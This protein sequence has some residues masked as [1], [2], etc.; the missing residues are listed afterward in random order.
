MLENQLAETLSLDGVWEIEIAGLSGE[1]VVPGVWERQGYPADVERAVYRRSVD[2]PARWA[3][4]RLFLRFGAVSYDVEVLVN[5]V[6][7]GRHEGM[8]T[9]F[10]LDVTEVV[11]PG[12]ANTVE[13]RIVKPLGEGDSYPYREVLVGFIPYIAITFGGPWQPVELVAYRSAAL[14]VEQ[15]SA[16]W[17]T[18]VVSLK[19]GVE[20]LGAAPEVDTRL[21]AEVLDDKGLVVASAQM[22]S[23][24]AVAFSLAVPDARLWSPAAPMCY[25]L[26]LWLLA[27]EVVLAETTRAFGF[28]ALQAD[29]DRLLLNGEVVSLR[30]VLSWGWKPSTL[31]PMPTDDE[32]RD[33]FR[34]VRELGFNLIKLCLFVPPPRL[35][36]IADEEGM[37]LW[38]ELPM[39]WQRV[40]P[41]LR[42][43]AAIEYRDIMWAV[44]HHPSVVIY[45]L[46]CE[47]GADMA[48]AEMLSN[49]NALVRGAA[50]N[51][52]VCDNSGSGEAYA[53]LSFDYADFLDYHFYSDLHY[54]VPLLDHFRRD[55]RK[56]RPWIFGEYCD[57]DSYRD[58]AELAENGARPWWRDV[59]GVE[60]N[61]SRWAFNQQERRVAAHALP[62]DDQTIKRASERQSFVVRKYVL[63]KSRSRQAIGGYVLTGLRDSPISTSGVFDDLGRSKFDPAAFRQFNADDVLLLE[64]GRTRDWVHGGDRPAPRDLYN[65]VGGT[66]ASLR[67]L[68]TGT[69]LTASQQE[70][71]VR[72]LSPDGQVV[73]TS[74]SLG[75]VQ[76]DG[77]PHELVSL[78][79]PLPPVAEA[80]QWRLEAALANGPRNDWPIWLY[81]ETDVAAFAVSAYDPLGQF[82]GLWPEA[83]LRTPGEGVVI[84]SLYDEALRRYLVL[85]GKVILLQPNSGP[86]STVAVPFWRESIKLLYP[87]AALTGFPHEGFTDL[88]FYHL[89]SDRAFAPDAFAGA[90]VTPIIQ[91]LDARL[92][93]L[94]D[95]LV[96][97]GVGAG[98]MLAST[99]RFF[100]GAGDQVIGLQASPAAVWLLR[101]MIDTLLQ[102]VGDAHEQAS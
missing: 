8:W 64:S 50:G 62:F 58:V 19:A 99:L 78:E 76:P 95:Y 3:G 6:S 57:S 60:G 92:F 17:Q 14:T 66:H 31:A 96:E 87:H 21:V 39:W 83:N 79:V 52:L 101:Q 45:S 4:S 9:A 44:H 86:A 69:T 84:A 54:F 46:G 36:E 27:G 22:P 48:D 18:G 43:Q 7:V 73:W 72:L 61:P 74:Q 23:S 38:L 75:D 5:G 71:T 30:G 67:L 82:G 98:R 13:L 89:A 11:R 41:H 65:Y 59:L 85:G 49:L 1:A 51:T 24:P 2:V 55:W 91:R 70:V 26:R 97:I 12:A 90:D 10:V 102:P 53:G 56:P 28:R 33:E 77:A 16:D 35:F 81:P 40:T 63:E 100:G 32:I 29:G 37:L 68:L 88:Q 94:S 25:Q 47:L 93:T 34:R 42:Q 20:M 80:G 15:L